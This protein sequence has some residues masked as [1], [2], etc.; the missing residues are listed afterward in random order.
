MTS[1][2]GTERSVP[3][4][5]A[6]RTIPLHEIRIPHDCPPP[7]RLSV[8]AR[9]RYFRGLDEHQLNRI[10]ARMTRRTW[11][12]GEHLFCAGD[13]ADELLVVAEGRIKLSQV[14]ADGSETVTDILV[15]GELFGAMGALG[16]PVHRQTAVALVDTCALR[17]GQSDFRRVLSEHPPVALH[18]LDDVA[19]RL[20]RA[21][22]DIGGQA[23][24]TVPA[25]VATA[26]LR[27]ADKLGQERGSEG[28]LLEV[29]LSRADLGGLARSTPE[30]VSRVMSRWKQE[31][32]IDS[33]RR[34]V[35]LRDRYRLERIADEMED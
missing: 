21:E 13:V 27:L 8:L 24:Q 33:G 19:A 31:G 15:P 3:A 4:P 30:S 1:Q 12:A 6:R 9:A 2:D 29:P 26:L 23:T 35:A 25:R 11:D 18:V 34:W 7:V 22:S 28:I 16:E 5:S 20:A 10:D 14:R 32:L 17:I